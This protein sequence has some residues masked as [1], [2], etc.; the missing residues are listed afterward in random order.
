MGLYVYTDHNSLEAAEWLPRSTGA[1]GV[2]QYG[3]IGHLLT[4]S[5]ER[6]RN[7]NLVLVFAVGTEAVTSS[8]QILGAAWLVTLEVHGGMFHILLHTILWFSMTL[9]ITRHTPSWSAWL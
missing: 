7:M 8:V 3:Y 1:S 5:S 4:L 6:S 2:G 9:C